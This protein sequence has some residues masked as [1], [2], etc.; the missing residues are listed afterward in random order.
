MKTEEN[1]QERTFKT[2]SDCSNCFPREKNCYNKFYCILYREEVE[3]F[4]TENIYRANACK[5]FQES[6]GSEN[7]YRL[8]IYMT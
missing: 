4:S 8:H 7:E 5:H 2:C 6:E 1:N 3:F